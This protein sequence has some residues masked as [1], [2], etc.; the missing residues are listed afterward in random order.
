MKTSRILPWAALAAGFLLLPARG[1]ESFQAGSTEEEKRPNIVPP[2]RQFGSWGAGK[3]QFTGPRAV[4]VSASNRI[5]IADAGNHRIQVVLSDGTAVA[6][7]GRR[8]NGPS[9]FLFPSGIAVG[10]AGEVFV[11]DTGNDRI[12]VFD[13]NGAFV[14]EWP[15]RAPGAI[16]VSAAQVAVAEPDA[17]RVQIFTLEGAAVRTLGGFGD[18]A[19]RFKHP[20]GIAWD[21]Q[22]DLVVADT[23]NHRLQRLDPTGVPRVQWGTWGLQEGLFA[24][25]RSVSC[26]GGRVYV[27]DSGNHRI[28]VFD[29]SGA[30]LYQWGRAPAK[31]FQGEGRLHFPS[32]VAVSPAGGL[33]VVVE[34]FD[35][36]C[37]VFANGSARKVTPS[38]DLPWWD[39]LHARL[40]T[41][42]LSIRPPST[43]ERPFINTM[44]PALGGIV[45]GEGQC[46]FF[47]NMATRPPTFVARTGGFGRKLGEFSLPSAMAVDPIRRRAFVSDRGNRRIQLLELTAL[48]TSLTGFAPAAKVVG[49]VDPAAAVPG[50]VEGYRPEISS[51]EALALDPDGKLLAVDGPNAAVLVFDAKL[52]FVKI[53]RRPAGEPRKPSRWTGAASSPDGKRTYVV[54]G[55]AF[56]VLAFDGDGRVEFSWGRPGDDPAQGFLEPVGV[57]VDEKGFV[58]VT[59]RLANAIKKFDAKGGWT[60]TWGGLGRDPGKVSG[61]S[62]ITFWRREGDVP[63]RIVVD[64]VGNHRAHLFTPDGKMYE[65]FFK[66]GSAP[67][68]PPK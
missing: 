29:R 8:G 49:S 23:G 1:A 32:A 34:P 46:V 38:N 45:D 9:E 48:E 30:F 13:A 53:L 67:P 16:A 60:A 44:T 22:G 64:D 26:H 62:A 55:A 21:D 68:P 19:G 27:A 61:P 28:Q 6:G 24:D 43:P 57:A 11:A 17:S 54:D 15:M 39:D 20:S 25:P 37:Q 56:Q 41:F 3:G 52:S 7:W 40:H 51:I 50:A 33:T 47:F 35:H 58:Y 31:A 2:L 10:P 66:G 42:Q 36:R 12:Q 4:A 65:Y 14:R 18:D 5:F 59:D 63:D